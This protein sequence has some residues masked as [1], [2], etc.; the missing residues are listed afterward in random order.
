MAITPEQAKKLNQQDLE[1]I[2]QLERT[3]DEAISKKFGRDGTQVAVSVSYIDERIRRELTRRY[4]EAGWNVK[5]QEDQREG[6]W[7]IFTPR[8]RNYLGGSA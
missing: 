5:Y 2:A 7:L 1:Q 8:K 6:D 4:A 3:L